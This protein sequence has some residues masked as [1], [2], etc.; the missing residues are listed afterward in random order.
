[1][2]TALL[3]LPMY[4]PFKLLQCLSLHICNVISC[5]ATQPVYSMSCYSACQQPI[6]IA[7][8]YH[9]TTG[10]YATQPVIL[11]YL[12]HMPIQLAIPYLNTLLSLLCPFIDAGLVA[13]FQH[14]QIDP[15]KQNAQNKICNI[16]KVSYMKFQPSLQSSKTKNTQAKI[17]LLGENFLKKMLPIPNT[18]SNSEYFIQKS[19]N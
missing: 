14:G 8:A 9:A 17:I 13:K 19:T 7:I 16:T 12:I 5:Y 3:G 2:S 11:T 10:C 18:G 4:Y 1:M 6:Y 15:L